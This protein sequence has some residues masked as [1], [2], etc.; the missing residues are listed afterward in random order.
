MADEW[1]ALEDT[2]K[3]KQ[4]CKRTQSRQFGERFVG[5]NC[6]LGYLFP[7]SSN[8]SNCPGLVYELR[9]GCRDERV[10]RISQRSFSKPTAPSAKRTIFYLIMYMNLLVILS[11]RLPTVSYFEEGPYGVKLPS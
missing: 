2:G 1:H 7:V 4:T 11:S 5:T 8:L 9:C 3:N 10:I 6:R